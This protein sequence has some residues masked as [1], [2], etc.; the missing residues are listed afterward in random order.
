MDG[1][2]IS[3]EDAN[4]MIEGFKTQFSSKGNGIL[5]G[6]IIEP[7]SLYEAS[8]I[9]FFGSMAWFGYDREELYLYFEKNARYDPDNLPK[10]PV[11]NFLSKSNRPIRISE[12]GISSSPLNS[13]KLNVEN[14]E[15][16]DDQITRGDVISSVNQFKNNFP[17]DQEGKDYNKYPFGFFENRV[18]QDVLEFLSQEGLNSVAYFF[19]YDD[20]TPYYVSTNR[21]RIVLTGVRTNGTLILQKNIGGVIED[22]IL[23]Q[24]SWP[25]PPIL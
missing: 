13:L 24:K 5:A 9:D 16:R 25:P 15:S 12:I 7:S 23:L 1:Y 17:K 4:K 18:N 8:L 22:A 11:S 20:T 3:K 10:F 21:I 6:G 19:G 14:V 2:R